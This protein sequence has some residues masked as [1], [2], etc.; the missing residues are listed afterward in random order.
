MMSRDLDHRP[1]MVNREMSCT[2]MMSALDATVPS[3]FMCRGNFAS[4]YPKSA[5]PVSLVLHTG[6]SL[7]DLTGL[8]AGDG[9]T[10]GVARIL[11]LMAC[12]PKAGALRDL[13]GAWIASK[14][15]VRAS[16]CRLPRIRQGT[17]G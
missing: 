4:F 2:V 3:T 9:G 11:E 12:R 7:P 13:A 14:A 1:G 5:K 16:S 15:D 10:S 8:L 17:G 6:A